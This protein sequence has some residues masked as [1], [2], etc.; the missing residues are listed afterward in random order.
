[1]ACVLTPAGGSYE[2]GLKEQ[3]LHQGG[4]H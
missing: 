3:I 2:T 4:H 1:M